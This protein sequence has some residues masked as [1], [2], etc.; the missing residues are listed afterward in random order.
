MY[1]RAHKRAHL[2]GIDE[3]QSRSIL[4]GEKEYAAERCWEME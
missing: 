1:R 2:E 4:L 3:V